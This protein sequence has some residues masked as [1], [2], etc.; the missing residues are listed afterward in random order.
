MEDIEVVNGGNE[1][2][3]H[4]GSVLI[5]LPKEVAKELAYKMMSI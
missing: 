4:I 2:S 3:I 5:T 1:V